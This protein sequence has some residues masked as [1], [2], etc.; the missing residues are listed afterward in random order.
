MGCT[1]TLPL[2]G[3]NLLDCGL[4]P[5][6]STSGTGPYRTPRMTFAWLMSLSGTGL[7]MNSTGVPVRSANLS[8]MP[9][10]PENQS[11]VLV[12]SEYQF[13]VPVVSAN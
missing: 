8:G 7:T 2:V 13:G 6:E 3:C 4:V 1:E 11:G 5:F 9:V 12:E 10:G